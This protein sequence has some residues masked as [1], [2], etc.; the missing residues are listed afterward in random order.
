MLESLR[1]ASATVGRAF[2]PHF[3]DKK[4]RDGGFYKGYFIG[5]YTDGTAFQK[6]QNLSLFVLKVNQKCQAFSGA[7]PRPITVFYKNITRTTTTTGGGL[8]G[9]ENTVNCQTFVPNSVRFSHRHRNRDRKLA[10]YHNT[11][12]QRKWNVA[13]VWLCISKMLQFLLTTPKVAHR[14]NEPFEYCSCLHDA[15]LKELRLLEGALLSMVT[16]LLPHSKCVI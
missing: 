13:G 9:L 1:P 10:V 4:R 2:C 5:L 12:P 15:L 8:V 11:K 14:T 3:L 16:L 7:D 6:S